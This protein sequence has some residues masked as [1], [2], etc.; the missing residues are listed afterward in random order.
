M[1]TS[2]PGPQA[3]SACPLNIAAEAVTL[4][5]GSWVPLGSTTETSTGLNGNWTVAFPPGVRVPDDGTASPSP[6]FAVVALPSGMPYW[7]SQLVGT[8]V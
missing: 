1:G 7:S 4:A 6:P 3:E 8:A 2:D 5:P